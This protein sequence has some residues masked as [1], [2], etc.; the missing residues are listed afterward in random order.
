M[1]SELFVTD[2]SAEFLG[3]WLQV[4]NQQSGLLLFVVVVWEDLGKRLFVCLLACLLACG[5][6]N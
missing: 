3:R 4:L 1:V 5:S 2:N 6:E